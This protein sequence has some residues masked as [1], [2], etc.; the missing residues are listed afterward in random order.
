MRETQRAEHGESERLNIVGMNA[1]LGDDR[2][3]I[4]QSGKT[5]QNMVTQR[6]IHRYQRYVPLKENQGAKKRAQ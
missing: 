2:R 3:G 6:V 5:K 1:T 4:A